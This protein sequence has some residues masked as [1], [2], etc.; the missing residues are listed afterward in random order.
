M[1][2]FSSRLN[3][4]LLILE[5]Y[6]Y[7][8][9]FHLHLKAFFK[10]HKK[11]GS[12]DRK[13]IA[14]L[15]YRYFR[16]CMICESNQ[17]LT[18]LLVSTAVLGS[19]DVNQ[20]NSL[21][22]KENIP[23]QL[24]EEFNSLGFEDR[25]TLFSD[26][27]LS[28]L[29]LLP[30]S[31]LS[32]AFEDINRVDLL[33]FRPNIWIKNIEYTED[34]LEIH[35]F[36]QSELLDNAFSTLNF[37]AKGTYEYQVQDLSSQYICS[38]IAINTGDK[39]WDCCCASG[40]KSLTLFSDK[41]KFYLSDIREGILRNARERFK[42]YQLQAAGLAA[43]DLET[44]PSELT[45]GKETLAYKS[46]DK[47]IVDAPC[48]GSGTWFRNPEHFSKFDFDKLNHYTER[49]KTILK[50]SR[51]FLKDTGSLY[52]LTCSVFQKE[53]EEVVQF[54]QENLNLKLQR[55]VS[56]KGY[57]NQSDSMF[58]AEFTNSVQ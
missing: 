55:S 40:G 41:A 46:F 54:A 47:I 51:K 13:A 20:W 42:L 25:I 29:I 50:N 45:F 1:K 57:E 17:L 39:V 49:Q 33:S 27:L 34:E 35:G 56:F 15:C 38:Q 14:E 21:A 2:Y 28:K 11:Y 32:K 24:P 53:N 5:S 4:A 7:P 22:V 36:S 8:E 23:L 12:K 44:A 16:A 52:Y 31:Q 37:N 48:S 58:M 10:K 3:S 26:V 18:Q 19:I 6:Q 9:P 43:I 30:E